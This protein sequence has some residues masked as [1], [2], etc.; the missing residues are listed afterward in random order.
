[1]TPAE[2]QVWVDTITQAYTDEE[3]ATLE[4]EANLLDVGLIRRHLDKFVDCA[5]LKYDLTLV[6][7]AFEDVCLDLRTAVGDTDADKG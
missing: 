2:V 1:M 5:A 4:D 3:I 7:A 6:L